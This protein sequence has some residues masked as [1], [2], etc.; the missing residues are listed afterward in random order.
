MS[1]HVIVSAASL[2]T[3]AG[4]I[5]CADGG[6]TTPDRSARSRPASASGSAGATVRYKLR[7]VAGVNP[8]GDGEMQSA[9]FPD[10][11]VVLNARNPWKSL[12][13]AG[14]IPVLVNYT[15]GAW[16]GGT[17]G[18]FGSSK[19]INRTTWDIAGSAPLS[20]AGAWSGTLATWQSTGT[21]VSFDGDRLV[22][23][24]VTPSAGGIHNVVTNGNV[25]YESK[26]PS[27]NNDWFQLELRDAALKFGSAS[28]PDGVSNP[29]GV[30]VAC[31]NLTILARKAS[32]I[33]P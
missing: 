3:L 23:G 17:C 25:A 28:T 6:P 13:V 32:L 14:A 16:T 9:W 7:F 10:S 22:N 2:A 11:G 20:F 21:S 29:V 5:A 8:V 31:V 4:L 19:T 27:G 18:T 24:V 26:D 33:A 1:R 30:E 12:T 15:H